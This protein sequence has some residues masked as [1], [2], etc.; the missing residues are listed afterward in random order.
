MVHG[1]CGKRMPL[2]GR[3]SPDSIRRT[4]VDQGLELLPLLVGDGSSQVLDFNRA[5]THEDYL[6]DVIDPGHPG[7][8][9]Q[10]RIQCRNAVG[11]LRYW[12][13]WV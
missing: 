10:L 5:L 2:C 12:E 13:I 8:A 4:V 7:I 9:I 11:F 1:F 6:S 3:N